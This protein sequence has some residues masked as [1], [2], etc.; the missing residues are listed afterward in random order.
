MRRATRISKK[1]RKWIVVA[2]IIIIAFVMGSVWL[3]RRNI[4]T[5]QNQQEGDEHIFDGADEQSLLP[6]DVEAEYVKLEELFQ[7]QKD[8]MQDFID[9]LSNL[10]MLRDEIYFIVFDEERFTGRPAQ[11]DCIHIVF[12]KGT[13][14]LDLFC[15]GGLEIEELEQILNENTSLIESLNFISDKEVITSIWQNCDGDIKMV[16]FEIDT[17]NANEVFK[18][19]I[20]TNGR[21]ALFMYCEDESVE[22]YGYRNIEGNWYMYIV[23]PPG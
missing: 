11:G 3:V 13:F 16:K 5:S 17:N 12:D 14:T 7:E 8:E 19:D 6:H 10:E 1:R 4:L 2:I 23:P 20:D 15:N 9:E 21:T 18:L 22:K